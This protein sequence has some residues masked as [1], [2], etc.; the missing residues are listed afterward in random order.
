MLVSHLTKA[1]R[2]FCICADFALSGYFVG[3]LYAK[4]GAN[5][6][7]V[8]GVVVAQIAVRVDDKKVGTVQ[9]VRRTK[10]PTGRFNGV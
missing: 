3:L 7:C 6:P 1:I 8:A 5:A 10:P 2:P 4:A 9:R